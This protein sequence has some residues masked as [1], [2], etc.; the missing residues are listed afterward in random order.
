MFDTFDTDQLFCDLFNNKNCPTDD[1]HFETIVW[2][3]V[4]M[5]SRNNL[6]MVGMLVIGKLVSKISDVMVIDKR[7]SADSLL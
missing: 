6:V 1:Q 3:K 5:K 7:H 4:N 2:I